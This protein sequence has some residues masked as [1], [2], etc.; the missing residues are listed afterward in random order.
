MERYH[1]EFR[2]RTKDGLEFSDLTEI[3]VLD[4]SRLP[5]R[6]DNSELWYWLEFMKSNNE[7]VLE[8]IAERNPQMST[9]ELMIK[10]NH[11]IIKGGECILFSIFRH[12]MMG[13]NYRQFVCFTI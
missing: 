4:L 10:T 7:E 5:H 13:K 8:M 2:Y 9:H 11:H 3:N 1:H 12:T 6:S